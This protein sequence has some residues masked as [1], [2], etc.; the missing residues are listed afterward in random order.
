MLADSPLVRRLLWNLVPVALVVGAVATTL[1]GEEGLLNRHAV[2]QR[3]YA[4]QDRVT[5]LE[6]QNARLRAEVR[7]LHEDSLVVRRAAAEQLLVAAPGSTIYRFELPSA[8]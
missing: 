6:T 2:K 4:M 7:A 5:A 3:L 1:I 8:D